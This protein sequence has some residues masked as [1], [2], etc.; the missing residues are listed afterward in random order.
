MKIENLKNLIKENYLNVCEAVWLIKTYNI[1]DI[2]IKNSDNSKFVAE[3]LLEFIKSKKTSTQNLTLEEDL[4]NFSIQNH[5]QLFISLDVKVELSDED[6]YDDEDICNPYSKEQLVKLRKIEQ[7]VIKQGHTKM[8]NELMKLIETKYSIV[9]NG[10]N[11]LEY[12][13]AKSQ[14]WKNIG[15]EDYEYFALSVETKNFLN[16]VYIASEPLVKKKV[17][18]RELKILPELTNKF[19]KWISK[20]NHKPNKTNLNQFLKDNNVKLSNPNIDKILN[21]IK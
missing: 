10:F 11:K 8:L 16:D 1:D 7:E 17:V 9:F 2:Q 3:S 21:N 15:F 18:E 5:L 20:N 12:Q 4:Y 14:F 6:D 19:A 13:R